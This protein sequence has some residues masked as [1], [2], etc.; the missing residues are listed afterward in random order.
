MLTERLIHNEAPQESCFKKTIKKIGSGIGSSAYLGGRVYGFFQSSV[1][2][3]GSLLLVSRFHWAFS[4][5]P[6]CSLSIIYLTKALIHPGRLEF[7]HDPGERSRYKSA[8][9]AFITLFASPLVF[10]PI[11]RYKDDL[12]PEVRDSVGTLLLMFGVLSNL[13]DAYKIYRAERY[14][15][16]A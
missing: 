10:A 12:I 4:I 9:N 8:D 3:T 13:S 7:A 1:T 5:L 15:N 2:V 11:Y 6:I 16:R 14:Q